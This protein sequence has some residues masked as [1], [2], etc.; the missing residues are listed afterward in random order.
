MASKEKQKKIVSNTA[1]TIGGALLMNGVLQVLVYPLLNRFM[2]SD[3]LG[4]LLY[5]MGLVAIL[6]PSVGQALNTS[7]LVV[8]RDY[9]VKNG[10]YNIL[11]LLFGGV[12][13]AVTLMVGKNSMTSVS[14][15][16]WTVLLLMTTIFRYYGDVEYRLNLN[17]RNYFNYYAVL[18]G[19]YVAG[20]GLY[21]LTKNW[22]LVFVTGEVAALIYL[23]A[24]GTVFHGFF[25]RSSWFGTAFQR[26]GFLVVSYLITNLTLNIDRLVLEHLIG[27]LAVTQYYVTSLIGKTLVLLVAPVNTI[28]ISYLTRN[29][30]RMGRKQFL[31][32]T[33]IGVGVSLVF[34]IGSQIGTPL[35]VWLF[36]G[37]LYESVKGMMTVVNLSQILGVLSAYLFIVVLTFTEEKWQLILQ[38]FHLVIITALVLLFTKN[39]GIMGF[40]EAVLIANA[41]RV[42]AVILLGFWKAGD[43]K[44]QSLKQ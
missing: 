31:Q 2:G 9:Q 18:T 1:Y 28:I 13:T 6:C 11:L 29:Q 33:G 26:G 27:H 44:A 23:A 14:V 16:F 4:E 20:F 25:K 40:A 8:G 10:D 34:F 32:F 5:L 42:A 24:T 30:E 22:F 38:I 35:F 3:Q 12:G 43:R 36:Y 39:S 21:L 15:I 7:R 19:G 37:D 17:Y 41:I